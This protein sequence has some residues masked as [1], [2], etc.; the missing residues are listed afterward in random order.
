[1]I[2]SKHKR[3]T[4]RSLMCANTAVMFG[5]AWLTLIPGG[6]SKTNT[7]PVR[8]KLIGNFG[9]ISMVRKRRKLGWGWKECSLFSSCTSQEGARWTFLSITHLPCFTA[10]LMAFSACE[11][12]SAEPIAIPVSVFFKSAA[13]SSTRPLGSKPY[14]QKSNKGDNTILEPW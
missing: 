3:R 11:K 1:M 2:Q 12:P 8:S 10:E 5:R 7:R 4:G 13:R 14:A 9:L 6:G